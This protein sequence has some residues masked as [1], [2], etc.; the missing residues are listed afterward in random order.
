M[1]ALASTGYINRIQRL[2]HFIN[3]VFVITITTVGFGE[4]QP[5]DPQAKIFTIFLIL[6]SV[7]IVGYALTIITEFIISKNDIS[8]LKQKKMQ[9][10]IDALSNHVVICGFGR[11]GKQ[12][13]KKLLTHKRSFVVVESNK[14][15]IEKHQN[16]DILFVLGNAN[17]D[18]VLQLA[19]HQTF[20]HSKAFTIITSSF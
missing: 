8:E 7:I 13:A 9:K 20:G 6:T 1:S 10:K 14:G 5:L 15:I 3:N 11:N 16:E 19:R 2:S 17:E 12:A 18:E 4:V